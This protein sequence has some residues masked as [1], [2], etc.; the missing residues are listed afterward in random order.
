MQGFKFEEATAAK[1]ETESPTL[2]RLG[3]TMVSATAAAMR[4]KLF[5][6]DVKSAALQADDIVEKEGLR[7]F[8][9]PTTDMRRRLERTKKLKPKQI[10][11]MRSPALEDAR[12]PRQWH[13]SS[14][15]SM[16]DLSLKKRILEQCLFF[17]YREASREEAIIPG[18]EAKDAWYCR[19]A[20]R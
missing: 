14:Q 17:S 15:R 1:L 19:T 11:R 5:G 7:I 13:D 6:A 3:R 18:H 20:R 16:K 4:W 9:L 10:S 8:G 2:S 12:A